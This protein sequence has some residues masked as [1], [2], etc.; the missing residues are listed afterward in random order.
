MQVD[1]ERLVVVQ[2]LKFKKMYICMYMFWNI[3]WSATDV[4]QNR[5]PHSP[6]WEEL[7]K[8][9][10]GNLFYIVFI[11]QLTKNQKI[12]DFFSHNFHFLRDKLFL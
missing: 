6:F 4:F 9:A 11:P 2:F 1:S 10:I 5:G 3:G 8:N 7:M 12:V